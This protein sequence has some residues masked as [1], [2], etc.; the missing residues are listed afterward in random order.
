[1]RDCR[2]S[3]GLAPAR[4][5]CLISGIHVR[6]APRLFCVGSATKAALT[7]VMAL[8]LLVAATLSVNGA[9]HQTLHND[10]AVN[11]HFCLICSLAKGQASSPESPVIV[12]LFVASLL[13]WASSHSEIVL[14]STFDYRVSR[15]RAPPAN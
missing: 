14:P 2:D 3:F 12:V 1:M 9:L 5:L 11:G 6:A 13:F 8:L 7:F 10:S 15:G 4:I